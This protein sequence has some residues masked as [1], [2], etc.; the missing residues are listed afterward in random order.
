[1]FLSLFNGG[2]GSLAKLKHAN[3]P[4]V[5]GRSVNF[6]PVYARGTSGCFAVNENP[7]Y[8]QAGVCGSDNRGREKVV[9]ESSR[10]NPL[11]A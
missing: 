11:P 1:M 9:R 4:A 7:F 10:R 2:L 8:S 3:A 6:E 5:R